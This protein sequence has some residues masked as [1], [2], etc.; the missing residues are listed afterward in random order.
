MEH[1]GG[2]L[3]ICLEM[4]YDSVSD[5]LRFFS[6]ACFGFRFLSASGY[7]FVWL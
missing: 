1:L 2:C 7:V 6:G 3:D 5:I 4:F